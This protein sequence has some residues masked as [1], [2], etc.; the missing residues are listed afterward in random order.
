MVK[1]I[2]V[3]P[4]NLGPGSIPSI[5][6]QLLSVTLV[7]GDQPPLLASLG[8]RQTHGTQINM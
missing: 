4:E 6:W 5:Q 3:P 2:A 7:S 8:T 1:S